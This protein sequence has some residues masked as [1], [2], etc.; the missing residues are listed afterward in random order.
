MRELHRRTVPT[1]GMFGR[2]LGAQ[3]SVASAPRETRAEQEAQM[4]YPL[5]VQSE[6]FR[7]E[8]ARALLEES[9]SW[10]KNS[11][12]FLRRHLLD[13]NGEGL[14]QSELRS[15][16][17]EEY[18]KEFSEGGEFPLVD[19]QRFMDI[20]FRCGLIEHDYRA[21]NGDPYS[22]ERVILHR[23]S[24]FDAQDLVIAYGK[25]DGLEEVRQDLGQDALKR[26]EEQAMNRILELLG[27]V[28]ALE[29]ADLNDMLT[30][31]M[32]REASEEFY[33]FLRALVDKLVGMGKVTQV[34]D[35]LLGCELYR[36]A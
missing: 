1:E 8:I 21:P 35:D 14:R 25:E 16:A 33:T 7:E 29:L 30:E 5:G 23:L 15:I 34:E 6:P 20:A 2:A 26:E 28:G 22:R 12:S 19:F 3:A 11:A 32:T 27:K 10:T 18:H 17:T 36:A 13:S 9:V 4:H 31:G 24:G